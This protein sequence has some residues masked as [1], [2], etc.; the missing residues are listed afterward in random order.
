MQKESVDFSPESLVIKV[1]KLL[2]YRH[3]NNSLHYSLLIQAENRLV[4]F[5]TLFLNISRRG[6]ITNQ[7]QFQHYYLRCQKNYFGIQKNNLG[8]QTNYLRFQ[9][10]AFRI[11]TNMFGIQTNDLCFQKNEFR[12]KKYAKRIQ[13]NHFGIQEYIFQW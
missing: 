1:I 13:K 5:C 10:N 3:F 9:T 7:M 2:L 4:Q 6:I 11:Q 12:P 8:F